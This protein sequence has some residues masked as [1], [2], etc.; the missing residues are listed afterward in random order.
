MA[1]GAEASKIDEIDDVKNKHRGSR[2]GVEY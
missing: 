2:D 1:S